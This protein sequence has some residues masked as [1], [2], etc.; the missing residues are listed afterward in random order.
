MAAILRRSDP[1]GRLFRGDR[2]PGSAD[3]V[4]VLETV[5]AALDT[6]AVLMDG[7]DVVL[8]N[9]T[10]R[11]M[12]VVRGTTLASPTLSRMVRQARRSGEQL[13]DDLD[14][15][16]GSTTRPV[17]A[18][19]AP[20]VGSERVV[21]LLKDMADSQRI[22]AVRRDFVANVS[23]ELKTPVGAL[24]L[25]AEA[26]RE[27]VDDP[28]SAHRFADRMVHEA[29]RLSRLVQELLDLSRLQ[30]AEPLPEPAVVPVTEVFAD[31]IDRVHLAAEAAN[32]TLV[33]APPGDLVVWG[34]ERSLATAL[35][36][37]LDN[38]IAY[39]P[40]GTAVGIGAVLR[41]SDDGNEVEISVKDEGYGIPPEDL[42]R[43]FERFYRVDTARSRATGGTGLGLAIVKHIASNA[44]GRVSVWSAEGVGSTFTLVLPTPPEPGT[45][46][47]SAG[48]VPA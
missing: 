45:A 33:T 19:V 38:A 23:H 18:T 1:A 31:A 7:S 48:E 9:D 22:E 29:S 37:L 32:V 26:F 39:S 2:E 8:A 6:G 28:E 36:N 43:V 46:N 41:Q 27:G 44:G 30:G 35:T 25:L 10:A 16:W 13:T 14:L 3:A 42:E 17:R 11:A 21:L 4:A 34:D 15:P 12:R 47:P 40:P 20:V 24:L 5:A